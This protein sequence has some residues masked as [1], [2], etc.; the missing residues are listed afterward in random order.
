MS[1]RTLDEPTNLQM[2]VTLTTPKD[3]SKNDIKKWFNI[4]K[5]FGPDGIISSVEKTNP[6]GE[7]ENISL[8]HQIKK[9]GHCYLIPLTRHILEREMDSII[10]EWD[11]WYDG[12]WEIELSTEEVEI[13]QVP[14]YH[15]VYLERSDYDDMCEQVAKEIHQMW[16]KEMSDSGWRYGLKKNDKEKTHPLVKPWESIPQSSR[17]IDKKLPQKIISMMNRQGYRFVK[18]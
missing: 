13:N 11:E 9:D 1:M 5:E 12:D 2:S 17:K 6:D 8:I 15:P 3:I 7:P 16:Y 4:I 18:D 14:K 10:E